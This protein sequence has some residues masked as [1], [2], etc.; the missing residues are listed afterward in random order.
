VGPA[1]LFIIFELCRKWELD[2]NKI[3]HS[4]LII[5]L[6]DLRHFELTLYSIAVDDL[7]RIPALV[8][9]CSFP[10]T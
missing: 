9:P 2:V 8:Q 7:V 4:G 10:T 1:Y 6:K 3:Y 5:C